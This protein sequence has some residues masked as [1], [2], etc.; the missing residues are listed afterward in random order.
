MRIVV[1][2]PSIYSETAC[3]ATAL[4]SERGFVPVGALCVRSWDRGTLVRKVA[5]WGFRDALNYARNKIGP[6]SHSELR[7]PYLAELLPEKC[8]KAR[9]LREVATMYKLPCSTCGNQNSEGSAAKLK[10]WSPDVIVFTGG[11]ILRRSVL[12]IP[13]LGV[14]N[15]HLGPLPEVR[16]MSSPEWSLLKGVPPGITIHFMDA[17]IDTG[18]VLRRR[19]LPAGN[20]C[21]TL[22]DLRNRLVAFGVEQMAE[23]I[24]DLDREAISAQPQAEVNEDHQYFVIHD[25]LRGVAAARL[26][27][28]SPA[29]VSTHA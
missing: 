19:E 20:P 7:N 12:E 24:A 16:G 14:L 5:Q 13:R 22:A 8:A 6:S 28:K 29:P 9:N 27:V 17:G 26:K 25:R 18:P 15:M 3:A 2:S 21:E 1:L 10:S 11:N 23:V 4:L